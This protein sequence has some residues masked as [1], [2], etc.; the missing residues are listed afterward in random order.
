[1]ENP[2]R[3][4]GLFHDAA[5]SRP[6]DIRHQGVRVWALDKHDPPFVYLHGVDILGLSF[7]LNGLQL[8]SVS[9]NEVRIWD[10]GHDFKVNPL[11]I[12]SSTNLQ[13]AVIILPDRPILMV[14]SR[15]GEVS[16]MQRATG[17]I[18]GKLSTGS[19]LKSLLAI[20]TDGKSLASA[21]G[22]I[23]ILWDVDLVL[24][25]EA[26]EA[27]ATTRKSSAVDDTTILS[28]SGNK[29]VVWDTN[30]QKITSQLDRVYD[31][32]RCKQ[33]LKVGTRRENQVTVFDARL[34]QEFSAPTTPSTKFNM[35]LDGKMI[36]LVRMRR[37]TFRHQYSI[38]SMRFLAISTDCS[39]HSTL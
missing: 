10:T 2:W 5:E 26:E 9:R 28:S 38:E 31:V 32:F 3:Q 36:L 29:V 19:R 30:S 8:I 20:S 34:K 11:T 16:L 24:K 23:I 7:S 1:M 13:G 35:S 15:Y 12:A 6:E 18:I 39:E 37:G 25:L 27:L 21:E 22:S 33:G 17:S 14:A 4:Q